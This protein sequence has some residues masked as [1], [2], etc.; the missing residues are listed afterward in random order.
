M[1][2][3]VKP[4]KLTL[5]A[6]YRLSYYMQEYSTTVKL[7]KATPTGYK[8]MNIKN[9]TCGKQNILYPSKEP[10]HQK[11]GELWFWL[12]MSLCIDFIPDNEAKECYIYEENFGSL[13]GIDDW[14]NYHW[15]H[16]ESQVA[17]F[18]RTDALSLVNKIKRAGDYNGRKNLQVKLKS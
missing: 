3:N 15:G 6:N 14:G 13:Y 1:K 9:F 11:K 17:L 2:A 12:P 18:T 4:V 10:N 16:D 7:I 8:F 5:G